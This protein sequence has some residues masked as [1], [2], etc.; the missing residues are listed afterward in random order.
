MRIKHSKYKN[1]GL[2]FEL[3][4]KQI[5]ADTLNKKDSP[6][7]QILKNFYTG[8]STFV[9]E[10]KLY[11]FIL[12]NK[13]I[14]QSKA[15]SIVST[16]IEVSRNINPSLLKKQKYNLIKEI[17]NHYS[18]EEFFSISVKDY[19]PLA[20]L[21]CL[22]EAHKISDVV[23]PN[24]LVD[25]KTTILEHLTK[26]VQNKKEVRDN[27]IE[28][29]GKYDKDLKLLTF[30]ILL[31]KFNSKYETLLPEQ[32][33]I[34]KEFITSVDS[35]TRLRNLVNEEL[36]KLKKVINTLKD[37][38]KDGIVAIKLQE[39]AKTI[40]PISK[41]KRV[42]DDHLVNIMTYYELVQELKGL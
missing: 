29:Y 18:L 39:V 5:A 30:K 4:V 28:E 1:T 36:L 12:K 42:T 33:N 22:M 15:E 2:I 37:S 10:F 8:R 23:D 31:E 7:V 6:A 11:E 19:K 35:S 27:L 34:L 14:S 24:F 40:E 16:I 32:K 41:T 38:V 20:A 13:S 25:N 9:R 26:E 17:K 3:L 21:Y